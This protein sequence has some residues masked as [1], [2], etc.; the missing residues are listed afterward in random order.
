MMLAARGAGDSVFWRGPSDCGV[1]EEA[2][3]LAAFPGELRVGEALKGEGP[4]LAPPAPAL[5]SPS[6]CMR[7]QRLAARRCLAGLGPPVAAVSACPHTSVTL[8]LCDL[9][10]PAACSSSEEC[11]AAAPPALERLQLLQVMPERRCFAEP[12]LPW[13]CL[14]QCMHVNNL[15]S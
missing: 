10:E 14:L 7:R 8:K 13:A 3:P 6:A 5:D 2:R 1:A 11:P 4:P 9:H 12:G 15:S